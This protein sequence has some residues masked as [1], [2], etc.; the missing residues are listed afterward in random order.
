MAF[1][2]AAK[3]ELWRVAGFFGVRNAMVVDR[4]HLIRLALS[5]QGKAPLDV[6][7]V[8]M[9]LFLATHVMQPAKSECLVCLA[10]L[11]PHAKVKDN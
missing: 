9:E 6:T 3:E 11:A 2:W 10:H 1:R 8:A 7:S 4:L 5:V